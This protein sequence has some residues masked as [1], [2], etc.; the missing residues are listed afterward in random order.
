MAPYQREIRDAAGSKEAIR[1][2][3]ALIAAERGLPESETK[4]IGRLRTYDLVQFAG[5]HH[6]NV[7]WLIVGDLKGLLDTVRGCPSRPRQEESASAQK[8]DLLEIAKTLNEC[9]CRLAGLD[10]D[11]GAA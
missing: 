7:D 4:W 5:K 10:G 1:T 6:V 3:V 8:R 11:G 9:L 2:R